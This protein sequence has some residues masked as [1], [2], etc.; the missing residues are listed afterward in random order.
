MFSEELKYIGEIFSSKGY[1][2]TYQR[3]LL[4][5]VFLEN[6]QM[7]FSPMDIKDHIL[8]KGKFISTA[9]IY[10]NINFFLDND[11][12]EEITYEDEKLYELK[13]FAQKS[14]HIHIHCIKCN[15]ITN[16]INLN[17][18]HN[19]INLMNNLENQL[20]FQIKKVNFSLKGICNNCLE[21][22]GDFYS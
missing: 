20:S 9:T 11:I 21:R 13:L 12:I 15:K 5:L 1:R 18:S 3:E 7:H 6:P 19:L 14:I 4:A 16:Y 2:L 17:I 10:R 22:G 8:Q